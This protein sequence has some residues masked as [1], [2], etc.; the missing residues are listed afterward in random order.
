M[1]SLDYK[2]EFNRSY[3][4]NYYDTQYG[5]NIRDGDGN[6]TDD[7]KFDYGGNLLP[8]YTDGEEGKANLANL[9]GITVGDFS[10][11]SFTGTP[12]EIQ[13]HLT[14]I[15][16]TRDYLFK[17]GLTNLQGTIDKEIQTL[18]NEGT[19]EITKIAK[20]GDIYQSLVGS[21]NFS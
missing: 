7:Y 8:S 16:Q 4:Q 19:K 15:N 14:N 6:R 12:E 3:L 20:E 17:S 13:Q 11:G 5:E 21:F 9:T 18:K 1:N 10:S 2:Q